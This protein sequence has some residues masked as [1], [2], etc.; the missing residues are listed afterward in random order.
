MQ[1]ITSLVG[2]GA[3]SL[4]YEGGHV[5][6]PN[7]GLWSSLEF[8]R[9]GA[10][11]LLTTDSGQILLAQDYFAHSPLPDL[12]APNGDSLTGPT[13]KL[14]AGPLA[15]GQY[16]Q[17][18]SDV[19]AQP[20]GSVQTLEGTG[21]VQHTDGVVVNLKVG[22]PVF[23]GDV[24]TADQGAK[25]GIGFADK[26]VF[27][28][29]DG[30]T[31][32]LN[33]L[34]YN[35]AGTS[36][37]MLFSV[38]KGTAGFIT[39]NIVKTGSMDVATPVAVMAIRGTTVVT[40]CHLPSC[41]FKAA[42]GVFL[43]KRGEEILGRVENQFVKVAD[44][45]SPAAAY[46]PTPQELG[47]GQSLEDWLSHTFKQMAAN[48]FMMTGNARFAESYHSG[49]EIQSI[50]LL[51]N[52]LGDTDFSNQGERLVSE[53]S[54]LFP[55]HPPDI[56]IV[57]GTDI[58]TASMDEDSTDGGASGTLTVYDQDINDVVGVEVTKVVVSDGSANGIDAATLMS[59]LEA[60][61]DVAINETETTGQVTWTFM[62]P[63]GTFDYLAA[64]TKVV[65]TYT[66]AVNDGH[67]GTDTQ[68]VTVTIAGVNDPP[69]LDDTN[70]PSPVLEATNVS[71]QDLAAIA[72]TFTVH[73][74]DVG[75]TLTPNVVGSPLVE[76]N[77][78]AFALPAGAAALIANGALTL[79]G[80]TSNGGAV[81]VA[82]SYDPSL[83]DLG[84]LHAGD[85]L[86]ITYRV[87]VSDGY[88]TTNVQ[89][90][91][92][93]IDGTNDV[94]VI[95]GVTTGT[96]T[97]DVAVN[98]SG[99]LHTG[100]TLTIVDADQGQSN[101]VAQASVAGSNG[102]GVFTLNENGTWTYRAD[103]SQLA[104]QQLGQGQ[105]LTDS[106]TA[107]SADGSE[108]QVVTVTID[109]T[110]DV[111]VIGGVTTGTVTEDV[112]VNGSGN[113]HTGGT[114]T[115]VDADQG[116]SNFVAQASV[117]GSNGHGVF[118]LNENGTWTYRADNSQ[119]AIQQ[120][121]QGQSLT[122]SFT[123]ASAD[124]SETQVVTVTID[125]TNDVAVIGG[126][127][128][129][130]VTEDVAVNG[131]GNL[132]TGG[133]LTIVDA[134]Q[135]QSN[136]VA[137]ASVAGS[138]GHGVFTLN[139][140]GTWTY[141][142]DNSQLAIQQL[143]QGQSLTDSFT[144][145]SA[146]G[147]ETQVVTVTIDGTNDVAV[148]GGVTTG[149]VT[150]DVAVNGSGNLHTGG[151]L[152]IVDADQ[153]Q[154][155]FVAQA[156][157]AGSNGHGV[158]TLNENGTWTYRADNSQLAIQQLG[159]GQ[160][161]T[162]S[163][164]AA[165]ADGS[166]TQVVTV[167]I[168]GTNDVA[169]IGG[170]TTGTVTEDVAVNGSGNLHTGGTLTIVD[171]DQGQSNFVAQASVAG[172]NGHGVFTLN[173]NGTWTYRADNSQ[174][175]IQQLGQGQSLT[176]S[177][178]A[179][180][181]DGSETQ[182]VTV[183]IDGTND[184]AV[185]G[186]VTTG[187][188]TEDV[189]VNGSGNLHTGGTL[190]IVDA[191]QGQSNFV[192]QA[193][194]AGSNGHGVF[195]LNENG[196]W[197]YRADN[198][199]LAIQ[200]L[201]QGQSLTDSFTAASA[202]GSET[203]VVT[204]TIDGTNDVAVIGGVTTGTVTEDVAVN[205]SGNLHTGGTLTIVDADQG[206][207][208]FVAQASV[209]GS[210]GH[211][212]FTLNENGTWTYRADNSQLAIQQLGQGQSLTDSF[213][214]ASADGSE[215]Q[216]VTVTIDGTNDVAVIGGVTTG[217]VTEDVAV[218]G[219]GN[220]HTG[221]TLTIVDADQGQSN[222]VAQA[223]V[224]GSNGHGV[225]TLN[226][227]GTWTYRADNSQLAIQQLGQGQSLTDSFT[228]ASA[229]GSETQ[230]VTV[231]IDGTNDVA[232]IG[233]VTTGTVT[234]D[235]AVNGSGNLHTGGTLTIV[236]ADQGQSNFVAQ[237]SVAGSNGHG[238]FTLNEN[239]TWTYRADNSQL[240]IQQLG[241]G[242]SLTDSFTAAS[243]D[244]SETQVVTVTIDGTND[245]AVIGGVTTGTVTEDV[246]VNGSGNLHTG[247]TLTIVDADQGQSNFVAQASV[248]GSNGHGVFTLNENGTWTYRADNSQLAIQQLGQGQSLTNSFTAASADG[249]ET[250]VV[251][252]TIDGTNDV[253]VIGGV[254]TGTVTEDVAV[255][256]SGNLHTG[257]TLTIVDAD[258][259][260][261]NFVAQASVAGSNGHGVF[262][263]NE[264]GTWTYRADNSQLAIQQLGQ[265]QSLTNSFTAASADGSETQ[266]VTVTIDGTNDVAVI[267]G[268][269]TGTVTEDV[270]V[271]GS[272][273]LHT[274]G[275]LT[276]VDA[277]QGQS[278]FVAQASVAGSNGH[279]VFTL[280]ENGTWTYRADNS[281]LAIQQLGQGQSLTNSFTAASADGSE[282]QVVTV[283]IDGTN[284]VAVIGGV[285]TGT[286]TEDVAVN[287]SG[288]LHTGGTLTIVDAD[289][290]QS[291]F[292]AQ[293]SV[294]GSNGHGVFTLNENGTWTYR[295]DNSQLAIQQLGQ[296]QS[297]TDSFTAA[298]ADGS[299]TQVV[300]VTIDGTNDV[301]VIGG[302]TTGQITED[303]TP[304]SVSGNLDAV[305]IDNPNDT[306]QAVNSATGSDNGY[307]TFVMTADGQWAFT[308]DNS[309]PTV[310]ALDDGEQLTD[311][312]TVY[313]ADGTAQEVAITIL[314]Q[315]EPPDFAFSSFGG[316][317]GN[318]PLKFLDGGDLLGSHVELMLSAIPL[319]VDKNGTVADNTVNVA[320]NKLGIGSAQDIDSSEGL[321]MEF[322]TDRTT[323]G[324]ITASQL[325]YSS[326]LYLSSAYVTVASVQGSNATA[327]V[328][329]RAIQSDTDN[330]L[331]WHTDSG[332][333]I[334]AIDQVTVE[335]SLGNVKNVTQFAIDSNGDGINDSF[336]LT[337]LS[338]GDVIHINS[339]ATFTRLEFENA[340]DEPL[341]SGGSQLG[342]NDFTLG[343]LGF[344]LA[345]SEYLDGS[346]TPGPDDLVGGTGND[347][348]VGGI[349]QDTLEGGQGLD[350]FVINQTALDD[351]VQNGITDLIAD[352]QKGTDV[353][354]LTTVLDV[355]FNP[356]TADPATLETLTQDYVRFISSTDN[357]TGPEVPGGGH[358]GEL[359]VNPSGSGNVAD[360]V[361]VTDVH[362][363]GGGSA[364]NVLV[365]IDDGHGDSAY[366]TIT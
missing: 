64:N 350:T 197:T 2:D 91:T 293:A 330:Q 277:D 260:Q 179:A 4:S 142:A 159:Q 299:E 217:T 290:G 104:I 28:L 149:T 60:N 300:T 261:S 44:G 143:G 121:G 63:L 144:A 234:E 47:I 77:G 232:V 251:T 281:Q 340:S 96:V 131:S 81:N 171:A 6:L 305:D 65:L 84:F 236:D 46:N 273:N 304:N 165:S 206:Q 19:G 99:N 259:G 32:V 294:A 111:A 135:G 123:A 71:A 302:V 339:T 265:G 166:E 107:A 190:T 316:V 311:T 280:N 24:V 284:D 356:A 338:E 298:S 282:T 113:L 85:S 315:Y 235:V 67:G 301:A 272:G 56:T 73:D 335:D 297:L 90:V 39:G 184:V 226:E 116:Q 328:L 360:F 237:A 188:V 309:N 248:A 292:V 42:K 57:P 11:L 201:G 164:T 151:T 211:G 240:A 45:H 147:S 94:A 68:N 255:N 69:A 279:G 319:T 10:N 17:T 243:A 249:S 161:L 117:A 160:S 168:D 317:S 212:V 162:D 27:A 22:T 230:V 238:V 157:V 152:T 155:N 18:S 148:I 274:G 223:S 357:D 196:T 105:S 51:S 140:N 306:W 138:N 141:R 122:D 170:V 89:D 53:D 127:T 103:N 14:L 208:N 112:A 278:N 314:G 82:Y 181:A 172:S 182:V 224:A 362:A 287:G 342:G 36:N 66:V 25:V 270:A 92:F 38:I 329:V 87:Q 31:M 256:G 154:S 253:A 214:A 250:Q 72:G 289:Q 363:F 137:Q 337:G 21:S 324:S 216:V 366:V 100:G 130:T 139:E 345:A 35:P 227:N 245:V 1:D 76:L 344:N 276:I 70:D 195:T 285:T 167:T 198:S 348:L 186:G 341:G 101:F 364:V 158:F 241:Q 320:G 204:V 365:Q 146:D 266:V 174:L 215:T 200:Q 308:L 333:K 192:A 134:D 258:Q 361:K 156:S 202:D 183:T 118:T 7:D 231:T 332:D 16:A 318:A 288:N 12:I 322:I 291:N 33:E 336:V 26:S 343:G 48:F 225:F 37:S 193:S 40:E 136:F 173:E 354:D 59:F 321:R 209:A 334:V 254:T 54:V 79:T 177:F 9:D 145:A 220:L 13:V 222:F 132:H 244:G 194:V 178:T 228:A 23:Q 88:Q 203:Q 313:T 176:D 355:N 307:G 62:A 191:D 271:N 205:G 187:T 312:F 109:G 95:G 218:N 358:P 106:F 199:Q 189:A 229:D 349:G 74:A 129:G 326:L 347:V 80:A 110:N 351:A 20:I 97:E 153:G 239:G 207:S 5:K 86:T 133:T 50:N 98:G 15:P 210:N 327:S 219:S 295:A 180:S 263:L 267:G 126:V 242:Q 78:S 185:I 221:G 43:L 323:N 30:G 49:F 120:L 163:F 75:D 325:A 169:V 52:L 115:I 353:V 61:P 359:W 286:V 150:E 8:G 119:L 233:G 262:T 3:V 264:N 247:G 296:G 108:T 29:S 175:A 257:G 346:L 269:T 58:A 303:A 275:T 55:D 102:H 114:L 310:N 128:T 246:A 252:V 93:T 125:G 213:T 34:V 124:G 41:I 268:V 83:A 283:T 352:Y 331:D